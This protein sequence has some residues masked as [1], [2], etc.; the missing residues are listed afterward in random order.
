MSVFLLC[1]DL[2]RAL[3]ESRDKC[4]HLFTFCIA[5]ERGAPSD[6]AVERG[7]PS[8]IA[9]ERGAPTDTM[10]S[11]QKISNGWRVSWTTT[12]M[13]GQEII[14]LD[15]DWFRVRYDKHGIVWGW[16]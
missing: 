14:A 4:A 6:I 5:V 8:D 11:A 13:N 10:Q 9:V 2:T 12:L 15:A 7:A 3:S 16:R 1:V